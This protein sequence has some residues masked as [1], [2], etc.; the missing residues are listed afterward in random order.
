MAPSQGMAPTHFPLERP[1]ASRKFNLMVNNESS[2]NNCFTD[3][4]PEANSKCEHSTLS[5]SLAG[6]PTCGFDFRPSRLGAVLLCLTIVT[7]WNSLCMGHTPAAEASRGL[8]HRRKPS[9][10]RPCPRAAHSFVH[11]HTMPLPRGFRMVPD[12]LQDPMEQLRHL[13]AL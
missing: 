13:L 2:I 3:N 1:A 4:W 7:L 9:L 12:R 8:L 10:S 11:H 5:P 6:L